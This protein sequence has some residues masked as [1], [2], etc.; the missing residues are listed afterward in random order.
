MKTLLLVRHAKSSWDEEEL[1]DHD[2][3]LNKRGKREAPMVGEYLL[4]CD[5]VP[6]LIMT[7]SA[8]R[9]RKTA[10]K[11]AEACG[12]TGEIAVLPEL[13]DAAPEE[14][15][16]SLHPVCDKVGRVMIVGHN[17]CLQDLV[18]LLTGGHSPMATCAV[19]RIDLDIPSWNSFSVQT[20]GELVSL[21]RP[22]RIDR[23]PGSASDEPA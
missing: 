8:K 14:Y 21:W 12:Y 13:Y 4:R 6:D 11:L 3:P 1:A 18:E 9:A 17:P 20:R 15:I 23:P 7:S 22:Q 19:A 5:L 2:R 16:A 10:L